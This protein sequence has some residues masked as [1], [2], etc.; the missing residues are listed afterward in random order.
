M[1]Q[2][3]ERK[4]REG[5]NNVASVLEKGNFRLHFFSDKSV[6]LEELV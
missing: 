2:W 5:Y 3:Q 4:A 1:F 6:H